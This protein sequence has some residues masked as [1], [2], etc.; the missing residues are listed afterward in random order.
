MTEINETCSRQLLLWSCVSYIFLTKSGYSSRVRDYSLG[1]RLSRT[2]M[3]SVS[4]V[5][6]NKSK[7]LSTRT[8][9]SLTPPSEQAEVVT[10]YLPLFIYTVLSFQRKLK[11][12]ACNFTITQEN[13]YGP[14]RISAIPLQSQ[15]VICSIT[16]AGMK[17]WPHTCC[18]SEW[19]S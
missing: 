7:V 16:V 2:F 3:H 17:H 15:D 14:E 4:Y 13:T 11:D 18:W 10:L 12:L 9:I 8:L 6:L 1:K 19:L 5:V